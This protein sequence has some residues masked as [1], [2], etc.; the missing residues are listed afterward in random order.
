M[1]MRWLA[2]GTALSIALIPLRT[3]AFEVVGKRLEIY[4][5][6]NVSAEYQDSD[7][8]RRRVPG[9][10]GRTTTG[11]DFDISSN[12]SRIGL[13][14]VIP[15]GTAF[16]LSALYQVELQVN[17]DRGGTGADFFSVRNTFAGLGTAY[18]DVLFGFYD[19]GFRIIGEDFTIWGDT[20]ADRRNILGASPVNGSRLDPRYRNMIMYR[21]KTDTMLL[22]AQYSADTQNGAGAP[23]LNNNDSFGLAGE[24]KF[25]MFQVGVGFTRDS[26]ELAALGSVSGGAGV[27]AFASVTADNAW[28]LRVGGSADFKPVKLTAIYEHVSA[29][30]RTPT[31]A[32]GRPT[33]LRGTSDRDAFG[34]SAQYFV[35]PQLALGTQILHATKVQGTK[36]TAAT[37]Y[38]VGAWYDINKFASV[39]LIGALTDNERNA[40]YALGDGSH[41]DIINTDFGRDPRTVAG[42]FVFSF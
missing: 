18:G 39:Y 3:Q 13:K 37:M 31:D 6:A 25:G 1:R 16:P 12:S 10:K 28:G 32:T 2:M 38:S 24:Y 29:A 5:K 21:F 30:D 42:G 14:G 33:S 36:D 22:I 35:T 20:V 15:L 41:G 26:H 4:G 8:N 34:G 23:D 17:L 9:T 7:T 40:R 27:P 11:G 19:T